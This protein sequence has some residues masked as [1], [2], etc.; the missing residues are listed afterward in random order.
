MYQIDKEKFGAFVSQLRKE[1]GMTQKELAAILSISDKA[2]SKWETGVSIPDVGLLIPLSEALNIT[3]TELLQC[4]RNE[5]PTPMESGQVEELVKTAIA[6]S[7]DDALTL[8][9]NWRQ[10]LP[11]FLLYALVCSVSMI[12]VAVLCKE[13]ATLSTLFLI[14]IMMICFGA[15]FMMVL[16]KRLP[17]YYDQHPI[18]YFSDGF[19]RM[20]L[21]G[22]AFHN[23]NWPHI[24]RAGIRSCITI[25]LSFPWIFLAS[26]KLIPAGAITLKVLMILAP[27]LGGLILPMYLVGKKYQ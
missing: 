7:K 6:Y 25:G 3:V 23:R 4:R 9:P 26:E 15:Y 24:R 17:D 10:E 22:L 21:P 2:I 20:N 12:F 1:K 13:S 5:M 11:K 18:Y 27:V 14:E 19:L 16:Q 8:R